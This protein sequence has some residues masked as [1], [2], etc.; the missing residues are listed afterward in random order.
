M[1]SDSYGPTRTAPT[2]F[3]PQLNVQL[4]IVTTEP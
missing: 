3:V 1:T 4:P 2:A